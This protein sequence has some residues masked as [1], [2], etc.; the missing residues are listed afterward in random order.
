[1]N[2]RIVI[3]IT[4]IFLTGIANSQDLI[5]RDIE[6]LAGS[7]KAEAQHDKNVNTERLDFKNEFRL[8]ISTA[9][10][11]YKSFIS[12]QDAN[13]CAFHPSCSTYAYQS[14]KTNG[15]LGIFDAFDRLTRCNGFSPEKYPAYKNTRQFYDPVK[16][17]H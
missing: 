5:E 12:S 11:L 8:L 16:K 10:V 15:I 1:M 3:F 9:Y 7:F 17:I 14:I 6:R 13:N 4:T 2:W